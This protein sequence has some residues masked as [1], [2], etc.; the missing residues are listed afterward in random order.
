M[1]SRPYLF[2]ILG[3]AIITLALLGLR[4]HV[5]STTVTLSFLLVVLFIAAAWGSRPASVASVIA[6]LCINFFFLPPYHT[7]VIADP[8][9]WVALVAFLITALITGE[10]STR[11]KRRAEV[12]EARRKEIERLYNQ[13]REAFERASEAEALKRSE[14][15]KSALLDAV[16]HHLRTPLTSMKAAV[17]TLLAPSGEEE[18]LKLDHEG[19][20]ELLEVIDVE[21]DRLNRFVESMVE[22]ARIEAGQMELR[23]RNVSVEEIIS[24]ALLRAFSQTSGHAIKVA[25]QKELTP[26]QVDAETFAEA[27]YNLVDNATKYSPAGSSIGISAEMDG[28]DNLDIVVEDEGVGIPVELRQRIFEKFFRVKN[29]GSRPTG[30]GMGLAIAKGIVEAHGGQIWAESGKG[31]IGT[32]MMIRIPLK[33]KAELK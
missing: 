28:A 9:N 26:V 13:L 25:V 32:R 8:Q 20:M 4:S 5:N 31:G 21:A 12:A 10:L 3:I 15:L 23:R 6:L 27:I 18:N 14:A 7:F 33:N 30:L 17:T 11:A 2:S 24:N 1:K 29:D 16:T 22:I 19:Q